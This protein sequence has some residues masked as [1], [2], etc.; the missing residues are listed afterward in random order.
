MSDPS[1]IRVFCVEDHPMLREGI[2][3]VINNQPD[4]SLVSEVGTGREA[5]QKFREHR[6][7]VTLLGLRFPDM[8]GIDALIAIRAD[9][10]GARV[11]MLTTFEGDVE[12]QRSGLARAAT[13]SKA[14]RRSSSGEPQP[15]PPFSGVGR[16]VRLSKTAAVAL[17]LRP[18]AIRNTARK[19]HT[20]DPKTPA[21]VQRR[22]C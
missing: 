8:S 5:I 6:P 2:S 3:A 13:C 19:T 9:F 16:R 17:S 12:T 7:D 1:R 22:G 10:P 4:M 11:I 14:C 20:S 18:P 21:F 15:R